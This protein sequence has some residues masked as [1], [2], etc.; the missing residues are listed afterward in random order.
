MMGT[1]KV[2]KGLDLPI[3]GE[4]DQSVQDGR[5]VSS[6]ALLASDYIG[7]KPT[8]FVKEGDTVQR[9]QVLFE[10]KKSP[11]TLYTS[12]SAGTVSAVHRGDKRALQSVVI[13]LSE[14]EI[15][16]E[17]D[18][19]SFE[20]YTGKDVASLNTDDVRALLVESGLWTAFRT[21]PYSKVPRVDSNPDSIF[22]TAM[23][24]QPL[25][26]NADIIHGQN[27]A[28]FE[29]GLAVIAKLREGHIYLCTGEGSAI[30]AGPYSG[31]QVKEF[32]GPHPAGTVGFHIHTVE[33]VYEERTAWHIGL[34]DVIAI[35][36]LFET[37]QL[38]VNRI[39]SLAGPSVSKPRLIRTR[40]GA[41]TDELTA[42]ELA[43]G[44]N[45]VVSGSVLSGRIAAGEELGYLGR[46]HQQVS[47]LA[48][49]REREFLGWMEPGTD[50]FSVINTF[51]S[52]LS[53]HK[54]FAFTTTTNGSHRAMVP[55]GVYEKVM[56]MD[57]MPTHLLRALIVGDVERAE[58][59][60]CLELDE[61][62]LALCTFVCPGK[63]EYGPYLRQVLAQI[64]SES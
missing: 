18:Q 47:V 58:R 34:Q 2:R 62:D 7:M 44:E 54:K 52:K 64:E 17:A 60:G 51:V 29:R 35:G 53:P 45:R 25:A 27:A 43:G 59:L 42:G 38:D 8:M 24:T 23:D 20:S 46:Y 4:P 14:K 63:Y 40:L 10:D 49:G 37:G 21:R 32:S 30:S 56:P 19:V 39:I 61:E 31:V 15:S 50:K 33:P 26:P 6:I 16:G 12:P 9:G 13:A 5:T 3:S 22:I 55:I 57:L 11:G 41:S 1:Y 48:E 36:A 28:A